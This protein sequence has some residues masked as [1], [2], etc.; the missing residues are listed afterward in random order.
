METKPGR[1]PPEQNERE[2]LAGLWSAWA[3]FVGMGAL[4]GAVPFHS[5]QDFLRG[6]GIGLIVGVVLF[7]AYHVGGGG[8]RKGKKRLLAF[9]VPMVLWTVVMMIGQHSMDTGFVPPL[10]GVLLGAG[11]LLFIFKPWRKDEEPAAAD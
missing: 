6:A 9:V 3:L 8:G 1:D 4:M 5:L 7:V 10:I 2:R 11:T